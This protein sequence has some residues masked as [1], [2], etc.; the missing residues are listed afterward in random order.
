MA[1]ITMNDLKSGLTLEYNQGLWKVIEFQHVK[2]GKG[3]A[4]VRSK[5]RNLRTGAVNDVTFRPGDKLEEAVVET[6][7]MQYLYENAGQ[8]VFM[9]SESFE[10]VEIDAAQ[11]QDALKFLLPEMEVKVTSFRGEILDVELP[12]T[13][14]LEVTDTQPAIKGATAN[15]GGKPAT[16]ETGLTVTVPDF[17]NVGD[18]IVVNTD[19][20]GAYKERA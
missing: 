14:T 17:V 3:A 6:Y 5:L 12:Q 16:L 1:T 4:F 18:K 15:G 20:G 11:I 13:V 10:Q 9:N 2:P 8:H 19:N 7:P